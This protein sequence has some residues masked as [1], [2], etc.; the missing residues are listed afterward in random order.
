[1]CELRNRDTSSRIAVGIRRAV[2]ALQSNLVRQL[3]LRP[4]NEEFRIEGDTAVR[5]GVELHHPAVESAVAK[6][7]IERAGERMGEVHTPPDRADVAADVRQV[8]AG[9]ERGV[10][11]GGMAGARND[12]TDPH[13]AGELGI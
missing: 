5:I 13:L 1:M 2:A 12:A 11:G 10:F 6:W 8:R 3:A 4:G 9:G 7:R